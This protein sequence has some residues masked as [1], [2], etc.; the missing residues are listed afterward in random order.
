MDRNEYE[1]KDKKKS[2]FTLGSFSKKNLIIFLLSPLT[3]SLNNKIS[4]RYL[5]HCSEISN[6]FQNILVI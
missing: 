3:F 5:S 2:L 4:E 1:K 6:F